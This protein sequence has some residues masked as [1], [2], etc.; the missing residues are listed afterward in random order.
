MQNSPS[1]ALHHV[2]IA[3]ADVATAT[4]LYIQRLGYI[5]A[6]PIIHDPAQTAFV[7]FLKL[8]GEASFLELV[9]P[10]SYAS[11]LSAVVSKGGGLN[12]LCYS[13]KDIEAAVE[14]LRSTGMVTICEPVEAV[15]FPGRKIAWMLGTDRVPVEL[16]EAGEPGQL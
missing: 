13:T 4:T 15:A 12:H 16:V 6:S 11:K 7:Q 1:L 14:H 10:D 5:V 3:V 9:A 2:G 8:P